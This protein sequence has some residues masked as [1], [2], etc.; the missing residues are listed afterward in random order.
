MGI[1]A[2]VFTVYLRGAEGPSLWTRALSEKFLK[3]RISISKHGLRSF[4]KPC[5]KGFELNILAQDEN[6]SGYET[7]FPLWYE[8]KFPF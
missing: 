8:T 5:S 2:H 1:L 3:F 4:E 7:K 6:M